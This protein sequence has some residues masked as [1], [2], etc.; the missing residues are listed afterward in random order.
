M[1]IKVNQKDKIVFF[2]VDYP[3]CLGIPTI[4][5]KYYPDFS[6]RVLSQQKFQQLDFLAISVGCEHW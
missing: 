4:M 3:T 1:K 2:E 5:K 6:Y